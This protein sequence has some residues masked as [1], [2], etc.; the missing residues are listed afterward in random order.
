[1]SEMA[2]FFQFVPGYRHYVYVSGREPLFFLLLAFV[3][4]FVGVRSY[5]RLGRKYGWGSGAVRGV[6]LHHLVPG[7][8]ASLTA[9]TAIV[10]F[11]PGDDSMLLLS[12]LFGVGA[13]LILDEFALVLHL[14]DVYWTE[15][16]RSSIEATLIGF[17]LAALCLLATALLE[18]DPGKD[19]PHWVLGGMIALNMSSALIAFLKGKLKLGTFGIFVPGLAIFAA[20]RLAKPGSLWAHRFYRPEKLERSRARS[21]LQQARYAY[22]GR[23]YDLID[24]SVA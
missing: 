6:H 16:G 7:I 3:I 1:M 12:A 24:G 14:D 20:A 5:T 8:V 9:G 21:T 11:R 17:T 4:T 19:V 18:A 2:D 22:V 10:A 15:E 13:A 23:L